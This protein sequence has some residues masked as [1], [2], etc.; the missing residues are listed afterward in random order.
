MR[1]SEM[2]ER[3]ENWR[4]IPTRGS[5]NAVRSEAPDKRLESSALR[6]DIPL[7]RPGEMGVAGWTEG[8]AMDP[9]Y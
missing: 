3:V 6:D 1:G 7:A 8:V 5:L 2:E 4:S 9:R